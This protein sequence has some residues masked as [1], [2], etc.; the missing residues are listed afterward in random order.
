LKDN[1][2]TQL[3]GDAAK[4]LGFDGIIAPSARWPCLDLVIFTDDIPPEGLELRRAS[5]VDW[6]AWREKEKPKPG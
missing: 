5:V 4:F 6:R 2:R 3:I 1:E